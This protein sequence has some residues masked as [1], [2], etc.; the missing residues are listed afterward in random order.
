MQEQDKENPAA[1]L[2][3]QGEGS[4][5]PG[6]AT[7]SPSESREAVSCLQDR[8]D[9]LGHGDSPSEEFRVKDIG[10]SLFQ[11]LSRDPSELSDKAVDSMAARIKSGC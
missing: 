4:Q 8:P 7:W 9:A 6:G 5:S 3:G 2:Y 11:G 1:P 10:G